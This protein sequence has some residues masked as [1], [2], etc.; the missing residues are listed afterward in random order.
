M[1][2]LPIFLRQYEVADLLSVSKT[3]VQ[4]YA[5][6]GKLTPIVDGR[7][8]YYHRNEVLGLF[9]RKQNRK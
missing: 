4:K 9:E 7:D 2:S 6:Q 3:C 5:K 1:L 8:V